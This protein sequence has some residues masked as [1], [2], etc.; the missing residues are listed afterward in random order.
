MRLEEPTPKRLFTALNASS[1]G[2]ASVTA[3]FCM[4]S[5]SIPTKYV[6]ARLYSTMTSELSMVGTAS[7]VTALAIGAVS[8][9][10]VFLS[11]SCKG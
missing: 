11:S 8:N 7:L 6:S 9:N 2:A 1:T 4:A 3:E 10:Q 5:F